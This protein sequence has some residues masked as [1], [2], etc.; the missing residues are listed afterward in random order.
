MSIHPHIIYYLYIFRSCTGMEKSSIHKVD[1]ISYKNI[2]K[3]MQPYR[4]L[5]LNMKHIY[6]IFCLQSFDDPSTSPC[7][8]FG[9]IQIILI[10]VDSMPAMSVR[11]PKTNFPGSMYQPIFY[12]THQTTDNRVLAVAARNGTFCHLEPNVIHSSLL[13]FVRVILAHLICAV[14]SLHRVHAALKS[15]ATA[16]TA[17]QAEKCQNLRKNAYK[18]GFQKAF[19]TE[20]ENQPV[21]GLREQRCLCR[22]SLSQQKC[23]VG[24]APGPEDHHPFQIFS[25]ANP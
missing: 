3:Y 11:S 24:S 5:N 4:Y 17:K 8:F 25:I 18:S 16:T 13:V 22:P 14:S 9:G 20:F 21:A 2:H 12:L 15:I 6:H 10:A 19:R 23:L 7:V 1:H